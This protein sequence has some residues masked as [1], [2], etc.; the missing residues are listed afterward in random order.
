MD[1]SLGFVCADA[2]ANLARR[3]ASAEKT[4][5]GKSKGNDILQAAQSRQACANI[6]SR[7]SYLSLQI[8]DVFAIVGNNLDHT[9]T[10]AYFARR[11]LIH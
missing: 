7:A 11:A 4:A 2:L 8:I 3:M 6:T 5:D 1:Q 9:D 10:I